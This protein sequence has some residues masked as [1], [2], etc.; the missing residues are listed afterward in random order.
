M[1]GIVDVAADSIQAQAGA[2]LAALNSRLREMGRR[3]GPDP[4]GQ[5]VST[6][7]GMIARDASGPYVRRHGYT[8]DHVLSLRMVL[9][10]G[11]VAELRPLPMPIAEDVTPP[12]FHDI[13]LSMALVLEQNRTVLDRHRLRLPYDRCG[14]QLDGVH[15]GH[16]LD[17]ARLVA[18]SEGTLGVV[19]EAT[20]RTVPIRAG[21]SAVLA[22]FASFDLALRAAE[23][24]RAFDPIACTLM[25]RRL[26]GL[27]R[28]GE[29]GRI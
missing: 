12:H 19:T 28:L 5:G 3:L 11:D 4:I 21:T 17:L 16:R 6:L 13:A 1:R 22:E 2:T 29:A 18:G 23:E 25:E 15:D 27:A 8:R 9:D 24:S 26:L 7:G 14:Y 20:L 10:S